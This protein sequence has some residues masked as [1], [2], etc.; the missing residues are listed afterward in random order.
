MIIFYVL[1][2]PIVGVNYNCDDADDDDTLP[3]F[4]ECS[5]A[6]DE[7]PSKRSSLI[8]TCRDY[9]PRFLL[10]NRSKNW[11]RKHFPENEFGKIGST[12]GRDLV[13]GEK[14]H[15]FRGMVI[16]EYTEKHVYL[17]AFP[18][19]EYVGYFTDREDITDF[20]VEG[21]I[22]FLASDIK[23]V[24]EW[25]DMLMDKTSTNMKDIK[26]DPD[27]KNLAFMEKFYLAPGTRVEYDIDLCT[28][29]TSQTQIVHETLPEDMET[30]GPASQ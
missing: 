14:V 23:L 2:F 30:Q 29:E 17:V 11:I 1:L 10:N 18:L 6:V 24:N 15:M 12:Y 22:P 27:F 16:A 4:N 28:A 9:P 19:Q 26:K 25:V 3:F 20:G 7:D 5:Y 8:G 21:D 13:S